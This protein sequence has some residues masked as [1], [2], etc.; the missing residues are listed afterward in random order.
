MELLIVD[1]ETEIL[2]M[3][4]RHFEMDGFEVTLATGPLEAIELVKDKLFN[5]VLTDLKM[6]KMSGIELMRE[7]KR[8]NPLANVIMMTGYSN[9]ST[10]VEC[11]GAGAV[12]YFVKP[13]NDL[14]ALTLALEQ[15]R[16]RVIRWRLAMGANP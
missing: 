4:R 2:N 3:L 15:A 13:F 11:M 16:D 9:M 5:L 10:V 8:I 12:D 14:E 6:P 1:D 7:I